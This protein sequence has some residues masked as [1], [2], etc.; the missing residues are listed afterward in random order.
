MSRRDI[1]EP[2]AAVAS[3]VRTI[4]YCAGTIFPSA[5]APRSGGAAA[6]GPDFSVQPPGVSWPAAKSHREPDEENEVWHESHVGTHA[7][8][9]ALHDRRSCPRS[10]WFRSRG[11][12]LTGRT[13]PSSFRMRVQEEEEEERRRE[14]EE[15]EEELLRRLRMGV[16]RRPR[17]TGALGEYVEDEEED[18][19]ERV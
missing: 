8:W 4:P 19:F 18:F 2:P 15:E 1:F 3:I 9:H 12:C 6:N 16:P 17:R 5:R 11:V 13:T 7:A 14:E 10:V